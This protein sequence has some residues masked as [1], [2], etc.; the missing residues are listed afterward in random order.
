MKTT[1]DRI[2]VSRFLRTD[3]FQVR[4]VLIRESY[5]TG[6]YL[7]TAGSDS[8]IQVYKL[9]AESDSGSTTPIH[10]LL[11]HSH[12]VCCLHSDKKGKR[13]ASGSW[14]MTARIWNSDTPSWECERILVDHGAAVWDVLLLDG[15]DEGDLCL[16]GEFSPFFE[17]GSKIK[18]LN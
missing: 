16:T 4:L 2:D 6:S 5:E 15:D 11:G 7:L 3:R 12:N 13:V 1:Q 9:S 18:S 14:D 17:F 10:T 8:L